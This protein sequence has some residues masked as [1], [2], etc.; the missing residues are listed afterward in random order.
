MRKSRQNYAPKEKVAILKQHLIERLTVAQVCEKYKLQPT[1]FYRWL[2]EFFDNGS[3]A[4]EKDTSRQ[5]N[6]QAKQIEKLEEKIVQ[7]DGVLAEL[8][9]EHV[10]LKKSLGEL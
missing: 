1:I 5:Q 9:Y 7:K 10:Q 2:K 4:F 6:V 3:A 8:M